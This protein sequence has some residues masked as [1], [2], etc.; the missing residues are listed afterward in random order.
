MLFSEQR[1]SIGFFAPGEMLQEIRPMLS[2][3]ESIND[4]LIEAIIGRASI[5]KFFNP[6]LRPS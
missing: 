3:L 2:Q 1:S 5:S 6:P 4:S